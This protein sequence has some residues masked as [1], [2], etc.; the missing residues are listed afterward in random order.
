MEQNESITRHYA[1]LASDQLELSAKYT[2][3]EAM[4]RDLQNQLQENARYIAS[5]EGKL[6]D[7]AP[8]AMVDKLLLHGN[9]ACS[10]LRELALFIR[11]RP[12]GRRFCDERKMEEIRAL[13]RDF[14]A[15]ET[16]AVKSDLVLWVGRL[17]TVYRKGMDLVL[18]LRKNP[19]TRPWIRGP[20]A[21]RLHGL[22]ATALSEGDYYLSLVSWRHAA[23]AVLVFLVSLR[24]NQLIRPFVSSSF[25]GELRTMLAQFDERERLGFSGYVH[26]SEKASA[27]LGESPDQGKSE[28]GV[29]DA[30][31]RT[32]AVLDEKYPGISSPKGITIAKFLEHR[33]RRPLAHSVAALSKPRVNMLFPDLEPEIVFGGYIAA[34]EFLASLADRYDIRLFATN[35]KLSGV[36]RLKVKFASNPRISKMLADAE[37]CDISHEIGLPQIAPNDVFVAY[38]FWECLL[39][40]EFAQMAGQERFFYFCQ[41]DE[42]TFHPYESCHAIGRYAQELSQIT[43]YNTELLRDYFRHFQLGPYHTSTDDGDKHSLAFSHALVPTTPVAIEDYQERIKPRLLFYARPEDHAKRNLF[44]IGLLGIKKFIETSGMPVGEMEFHGIGTMTFSGDLPLGGGHV[45]QV[46]P[47]LELG[48][49]A[50][51]LAGFDIGV[52][53]MYA[54]HPSIIPFEMASAGVLS[55]TNTFGIRTAELL[56]SLSPNLIPISP[57]VEGVAEGIARAFGRWRQFQ[58]RINGSEVIWSRSWEESF[59]NGFQREFDRMLTTFVLPE[60]KGA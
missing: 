14:G 10:Q 46:R 41:E 56:Q 23:N 16:Q 12:W 4:A 60:K 31:A 2:E 29:E 54:P 32:A 1:K 13:H 21:R 26:V 59:H 6:A 37:F 30:Q 43:I 3:M 49:Y 45:L 11:S 58:D 57:S 27:E 35:H 33:F 51:A 34:F 38:S 17:R 39:A 55:V 7:S 22:G 40:H 36:D 50:K 42:T 48:S 44:E 24:R 28:P 8:Q 19:M 47:K 20:V 25:I 15:V 9:E 18:Q 53:L 5:L 52:S